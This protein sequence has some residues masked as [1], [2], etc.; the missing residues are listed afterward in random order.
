MSERKFS[1]ERW[2]NKPR[3]CSSVMK[4]VALYFYCRYLPYVLYM[5]DMCQGSFYIHC[6]LLDPHVLSVSRRGSLI[7]SLT[8]EHDEIV[9]RCLMYSSWSLGIYNQDTV[10]YSYNL[11][12]DHSFLSFCIS[13]SNIYHPGSICHLFWI[14]ASTSNLLG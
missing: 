2:T 11:L 9:R 4:I 5:L 13:C 8:E 6:T 1:P 14:T 3:S 7:V 10:L 12:I